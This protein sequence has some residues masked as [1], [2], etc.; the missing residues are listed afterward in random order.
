MILFS[1][2]PVIAY[3]PLIDIYKAGGRGHSRAVKWLGSLDL[4]CWLQQVPRAH[5]EVCLATLNTARSRPTRRCAWRLSTP[6]GLVSSFNVTLLTCTT[7]YN[8]CQSPTGD[9]LGDS[10]H[11]TVSYMV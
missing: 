7:G 8:R 11:R 9:V 2:R 4:D 6:H 1:T 10:Q 5:P 3:R